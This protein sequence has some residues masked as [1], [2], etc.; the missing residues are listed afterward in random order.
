[1]R[2][3]LQA[4]RGAGESPRQVRKRQQ[5]SASVRQLQR[6]LLTEKRSPGK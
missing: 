3:E 4:D 1:M 5:N 2:Y 6:L